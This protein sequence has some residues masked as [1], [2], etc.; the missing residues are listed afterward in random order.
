MC[1][2]A[3]FLPYEVLPGFMLRSVVGAAAANMMLVQ[4]FRCA[5]LIG[6]L[7]RRDGIS[8]DHGVIGT[9]SRVGDLAGLRSGRHQ[10]GD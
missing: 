8:P 2:I 9:T 5:H 1:Y 10:H 4:W 6:V 3:C 7:A